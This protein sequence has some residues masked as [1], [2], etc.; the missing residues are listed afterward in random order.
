M[1]C[2]VPGLGFLCTSVQYGLQPSGLVAFGVYPKQ[3]SANSNTTRWA[4][5][6]FYDLFV[7][8]NDI[9]LFDFLYKTFDWWNFNLLKECL[10]V[11]E[12]G[13]KVAS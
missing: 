12:M 9:C 10:I 13:N 3:I 4:I 6:R 8:Q 7:A 11:V 1:F 2:L 5:G